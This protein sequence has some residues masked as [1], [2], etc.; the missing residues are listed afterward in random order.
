[1]AGNIQAALEKLKSIDGFIGA[2]LVD[3]DSGMMLG[4]EGGA[5]INLEI[6]AAA[7]T[8]VVRAKRKAVKVLDLKDD[9]EDILIS[10]GKQY[11]LIRPVR[12]RPA[13]FFY[14]VLDRGRANLAMSRLT[15]ADAEKTLEL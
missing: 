5:G 15:V 7:N 4:A 14:V 3:S 9:I 6:A 11:H 8:E 12:A 13:I 1:M 2:A 10:L